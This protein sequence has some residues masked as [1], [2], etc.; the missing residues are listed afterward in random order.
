MGKSRKQAEAAGKIREL[1]L[2][3]SFDVPSRKMRLPD[4]QQWIVFQH[5]ERQIGIDTAT[6]VWVRETISA[7]W[8]CIALPCTISGAVQAVEFL[9]RD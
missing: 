2:Q 6:G 8:K 1:L 4:E 9:T 7:S 3:R 5:G